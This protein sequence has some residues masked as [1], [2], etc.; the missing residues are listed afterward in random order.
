MSNK[1]QRT[2]LFLT[3]ASILA[4]SSA[5]VHAAKQAPSREE[6]L[7]ML[8]QQQRQL[9]E[10][11]AMLKQTQKQAETATAKATEA[12]AK[13]AFLDTVQIGG[14]LELE[15][16]ETQDFTD[17]DTSDLSLAKVELTFSAK[18]HE[19]VTTNIV[20]L[21]EDGSNNITL[22]EATIEIANTEAFPLYTTVGKW[23]MP[24]GNYDT[25]MSSD[26][27]TKNLG[28]TKENAILVGA[29][30]NGFSIEAFAF[31]GDT[32]KSGKGNNIDQYGIN[33]G[34]NG[35]EDGLLYSIGAA[36]LNN[37]A[38]S[39]GIN[40]KLTGATALDDYVG[41]I[42]LYGSLSLN[43]VSASVGYVKATDNFQTGELA[44]N[45][46]GAQPVAWNTEISYTMDIL[47]KETTFAATYQGTDEALALSLP[48]TRLGGAVTV[49]I[50]D[51]TS[52]TLEYLADEDYNVSEGGTGKDGHT[53][54]AKLAVE[55]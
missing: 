17:T 29:T 12:A 23:V 48:E 47:G 38:D 9:D 4:F 42:S 18:P 8:K 11:Q 20:A 21:Y 13:P 10:L 1:V 43:G 34:I 55:F 27:L 2:A 36:Y 14:T 25:A 41:A 46:Q 45:G 6:L 51:Q 35:E 37:I 49:G 7:S 24:F 19:Y 22:D 30:Y 40:N 5:H 32:Q 53:T 26:P 15:A 28:E 39:D 31:N 44:F 52:L 3:A 16:T 54:T 33:A 50:Y